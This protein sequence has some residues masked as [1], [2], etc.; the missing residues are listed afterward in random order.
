MRMMLYGD[1][2]Q[3][4]TMMEGIQKLEQEINALP[5]SQ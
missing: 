4:D 1:V 2:P 5:D 3:F